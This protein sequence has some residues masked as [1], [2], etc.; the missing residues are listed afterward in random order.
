MIGGVEQSLRKIITFRPSS[1]PASKVGDR[2]FKRKTTFPLF[3]LLCARFEN[4]RG[5]LTD[6]T[7]SGTLIAFV[8]NSKDLE[9]VDRP[10]RVSLG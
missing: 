8:R 5:L 4:D 10:L 2:V 7:R 9:G 1:T 3:T 6:K